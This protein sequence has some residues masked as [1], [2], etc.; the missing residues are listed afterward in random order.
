M[1][2]FSQNFV[3]L[4]EEV[5]I[6]RVLDRCAVINENDVRNLVKKHAKLRQN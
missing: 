4:C 1:I 5:G 6:C 2:L 3:F